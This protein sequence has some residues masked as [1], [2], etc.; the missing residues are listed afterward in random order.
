[1]IAQALIVLVLKS[2]IEEEEKDVSD[3]DNVVPIVPVEE[4]L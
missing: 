4:F 1:M 3:D 2:F